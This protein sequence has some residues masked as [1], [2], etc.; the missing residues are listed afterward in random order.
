MI[1][2]LVYMTGGIGLEEVKTD[3]YDGGYSSQ[4]IEYLIM[5]LGVCKGSG[6]G[7]FHG[8]FV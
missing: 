3:H 5:R 2:L 7:S 6:G 1:D 4:S 8:C